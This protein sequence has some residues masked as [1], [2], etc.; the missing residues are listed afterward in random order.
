MSNI[1]KTLDLLQPYV[2]GIR[3]LE[4]MPLVDVVFKEGWAVQEDPKIKMM[5]GN[6]E[7]NYYML[8]S[9]VKGVGLDELLGFVD[10][11]IK[12]NIEREKKHDLLREKV[13]EL[14]E[15]FKRNTLDKLKRLK[16]AFN[17]ED[18]VPNLDE[19]DLDI[20]E[21]ITPAPVVDY[22]E[23]IEEM[24][25]EESEYEEVPETFT[26]AA[27]FLDE[28][29]QPIALTEEEKEILAE[30]ARAE[31]NRKMIES[32]KVSGKKPLKVELPPK[33]KIEMAIN[34]NYDSDADCECGPDE[35][36]NKCIDNKY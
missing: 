26:D 18:L 31:R 5:K 9:E 8:F 35:A 32:K 13:Q 1:Q 3:Y 2:I 6:E 14:K 21:D 16:F 30:E 19:F 25:Y 12:L 33:R 29:G 7:M 17:E 28:N 36:C 10:K 20:D 15:V 24:I 4:G 22:P 23:P 34:E 27:E 11:T